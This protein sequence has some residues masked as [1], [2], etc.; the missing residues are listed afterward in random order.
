MQ[1]WYLA[2]LQ[3]TIFLKQKAWRTQNRNNKKRENKT[4]K[5]VLQFHLSLYNAKAHLFRN[6]IFYNFFFFWIS[7]YFPK[8]VFSVTEK[9]PSHCQDHRYYTVMERARNCWCDSVYAA[10]ADVFLISLPFIIIIY[11][12]LEYYI[13]F[14]YLFKWRIIKKTAMLMQNK[15][16]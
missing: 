3:S 16:K 7:Q 9:H 5:N 12:F 4:T 10:T 15:T 2:P 14:T 11:F 13:V 8:Y 6:F 1:Y